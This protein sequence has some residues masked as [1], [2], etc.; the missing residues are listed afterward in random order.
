MAQKLTSTTHRPLAVLAAALLI[1]AQLTAPGAHAQEARDTEGAPAAAND[2]AL[3]DAALAASQQ[4]VVMLETDLGIGAGI[5]VGRAGGDIAIATANHVVRRGALAAS[6]VRARFR[7]RP[8]SWID[9]ELT[10]TFAADR[11][12]DLA[13]VRVPLPRAPIADACDLP[14]D[15][16]GS[17]GTVQRGAEVFPVGYPFGA[18]WAT[19]LRADLVA[20]AA[21]G[22]ISFQSSFIAAGMSGGA[23]LDADGRLIGMIKNDQPPFGVAV[24]LDT[25]LER[26]RGWGYQ[27]LLHDPD[28]IRTGAPLH[29]AAAAGDDERVAALI[30]ACQDIDLPDDSGR[31]PLEVAVDAGATTV[32]RRLLDM[33]A[34]LERDGA[35]APLLHAAAGTGDPALVELLL[36]RGLGVDTRDEYGLTALH[37]AA[38]DGHIAVAQHLL[39]AGADTAVFGNETGVRLAR[40][41]IS[42]LHA[43][44][45]H[46]QREMVDLLLN[47]GAPVNLRQDPGY[48]AT[49]LHLA[50]FEGQLAIVRVLADAGADIHARLY[51]NPDAETALDLAITGGAERTSDDLTE[52][53]GVLVARGADPDRPSRSISKGTAVH[54]AVKSGRADV[55]DR[56]AEL[57][58][59]LEATDNRGE[60]ALHHAVLQSEPRASRLLDVL[61]RHGAYLDARDNAGMTP[62]HVAAQNDRA[63]MVRRLIAAGAPI[64]ALDDKARSP[65]FLAVAE[66]ARTA[67]AALLA[68]GADPNA[69]R[70]SEEQPLHAAADAGDRRAVDLLIAANAYLTPTQ[71]GGDTPLHLAVRRLGHDYVKRDR[72]LHDRYVAIAKALIEAGAHVDLTPTTRAT[73]RAQ[74]RGLPELQ[75]LLAT[76]VPRVRTATTPDARRR[77]R[78]LPVVQRGHAHG[79]SA[80]AV[81]PDGTITATGGPGGAIILWDAAVKT[82]V[83]RLAGHT[84]QVNALAFSADG[85]TLVSAGADG[86]V[87]TWNAGTGALLDGVELSDPAVSAVVTSD[88]RYLIVA[89]GSEDD[90]SPE[91]G[92]SIWHR[93]ADG[94]SYTPA[95]SAA[96]ALRAVQL[97]PDERSFLAIGR[98]R[99][100]WLIGVANGEL[101]Q[102]WDDV[103]AA[104][105]ARDPARMLLGR[106]GYIA[107]FDLDQGVELR[108]IAARSDV[109]FIS[110]TP[111]PDRVII[112]ESD[113][114]GSDILVMDLTSG[115]TVARVHFHGPIEALLSTRRD[116]LA[117]RRAGTNYS[118]VGWDGESAEVDPRIGPAD[119]ASVAAL[120]INAVSGNAIVVGRHGHTLRAFVIDEGTVVATHH[121]G[122][123]EREWS[124]AAAVAISRNG[125]YVAAQAYGETEIS[126]WSVDEDFKVRPLVSEPASPPLLA[127]SANGDWLVS[128]SRA[129][130]IVWETRTG[131]RLA[132]LKGDAPR[133]LA[134]TGGGQ[135]VVATTHGQAPVMLMD[136]GSGITTAHPSWGGGFDVM[137]LAPDETQLALAGPETAT[138]LWSIGRTR[139]VGTVGRAPV[140]GLAFSPDGTRLAIAGDGTLTVWDLGL[141]TSG[142]EL[143]GH[144]GAVTAVAYARDTGPI[145]SGGADG[146]VRFWDPATGSELV[147]VVLFENAD[148]VSQTTDGKF[149]AWSRAM[150]RIAMVADGKRLDPDAIRTLYYD[151]EAPAGALRASQFGDE[152]PRQ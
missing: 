9:A 99:G 98:Y 76:A 107:V 7:A 16:L 54:L 131:R 140:H 69:A 38:R 17:P 87:R 75:A 70:P 1:A 84:G 112:T 51:T 3:P 90:R 43:A 14:F 50:A 47:A 88:R 58:A 80:V 23:L 106:D 41:P 52:I 152:G 66:G 40:W 110:P 85:N 29:A 83:L 30:A 33:G 59:N 57:G 136:T 129:G 46:G 123:P 86:R 126:L 145:V 78:D 31:T 18:P 149:S 72:E 19:P 111:E 148:W 61:L 67:V 125:R 109:D 36:A 141:P 32:V 8:S 147:S 35:P 137:A 10:E 116:T 93:E 21:A 79:V 68:L 44:A 5:V 142:L 25:V 114:R 12:L 130:I 133:A 144:D 2:S 117:V 22:L 94:G 102:A 127:F 120:A 55:L 60:T 62:L 134:T 91:N 28:A 104:A 42:P 34:R 128:R 96:G 77:T 119:T 139:E 15:R 115:A 89:S 48:G 103:S 118:L 105:F 20:S 6:S 65:L 121:L 101:K 124:T 132:T 82:Q 49:P 13:V 45:R 71:R 97:S 138:R 27:V 64:D 37:V 11:D 63:E 39:A 143:L 53:V 26:I 24:A 81:T 95:V 135:R 74:T 146:T 113:I 122:G 108:R 4:L 151:P 150:P 92:L 100:A 56:L 73:L